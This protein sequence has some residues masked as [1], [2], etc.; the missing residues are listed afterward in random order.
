MQLVYPKALK[1]DLTPQQDSDGGL[2][3]WIKWAP[4]EDIITESSELTEPA[5]TVFVQAPWILSEQD[6]KVFANTPVVGRFVRY[7]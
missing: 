4:D 3:Q 7:I 6:L 1:Y 5:M 2:I